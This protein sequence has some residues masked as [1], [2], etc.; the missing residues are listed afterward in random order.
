MSRTSSQS[1][2]P[3]APPK[4]RGRKKLDLSPEAEKKIKELEQRLHREK[5]M[6]IIAEQSKKLKNMLEDVVQKFQ[7]IAA[8][9]GKVKLI[10]QAG[11]TFFLKNVAVKL[12]LK[13]ENGNTV[14]VPIESVSNR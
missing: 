1:V 11:K 4:K 8:A 2:D 13:D 6:I 12:T 3:N 5:E 10:N 14:R 7:N 9:E